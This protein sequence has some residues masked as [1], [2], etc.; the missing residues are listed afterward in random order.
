M[1]CY[2]VPC[3]LSF[4][5]TDIC[6]IGAINVEIHCL[7]L[8][9][10]VGGFNID[11][12]KHVRVVHSSLLFISGQPKRHLLTTGWS[13]F[14]STKRLFAG[15]SVLFIRL[16]AYVINEILDR[17][18]IFCYKTETILFFV[19]MKNHSFFWV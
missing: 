10:L 12:G 19:E 2:P 7:A 14:V 18:N 1:L 5:P 6:S 9:L 11:C 16:E 13:V 17:Y 4:I 15:D 3:F 8:Q